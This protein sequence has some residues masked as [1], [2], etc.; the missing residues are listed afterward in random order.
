MCVHVYVGWGVYLVVKES[1]VGNGRH[2]FDLLLCCV[3]H[4]IHV[5]LEERDQDGQLD[6]VHGCLA[7]D[8]M[9]VCVHREERDKSQG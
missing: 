5:L 7:D 9:P 4:K 8:A 6:G 3:I 2:N 1:L